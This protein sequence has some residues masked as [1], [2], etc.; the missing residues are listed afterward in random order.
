M[1]VSAIDL[2]SGLSDLVRLEVYLPR[3]EVREL[4]ADVS[5]NGLCYACIRDKVSV[6]ARVEL[7][8]TINDLRPPYY[9]HSRKTCA[10]C[11]QIAK[12]VRRL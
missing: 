2:T 1:G 12:L 6:P 7:R 10:A 4:L 11:G 3:S 5:P 9:Q 8:S